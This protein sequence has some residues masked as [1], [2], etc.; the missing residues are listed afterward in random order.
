MTDYDKVWMKKLEKSSEKL[1]KNV[2]NMEI[3]KSFVILMLVG[4]GSGEG[5]EICPKM[6]TC[7]V[8]EG[9]KRADCR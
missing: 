7:D 5:K 6:C 8:F 4:L 2:K 9:Y 1:H 3:W